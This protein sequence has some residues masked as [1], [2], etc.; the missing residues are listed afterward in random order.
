MEHFKDAF[1]KEFGK[2]NQENFGNIFNEIDLKMKN[3]FRK[4]QKIAAIIISLIFA[5]V[6][7][8]IFLPPLNIRSIETWIF[9][10]LTFTIFVS[11]SGKAFKSYKLFR[12]VLVGLILLMLILKIPGLKIFNSR[13]YANIIKIENSKFENDIA[14][15]PINKIPTIDRDS[16]IKLGSRKMGELLDL[17]SQFDIDDTTYTQINYKDQPIRVTPLKYNG[18]IKYIFNMSQGLP[19][20]LKVDIV[21]GNTELTKL[22]NKIKISKEDYFFRNVWRYARLR[23]PSEIFDNISFEIDENG[24]PYWVI[25]TYQPKI[26]IF[27]GLDVNGAILINVSTGEHTKYDLNNI[28]KW[29]DRI[30]EAD[31]IIEQLDWNGLYQGGYINSLFAQK[32]VLKTTEG[33]N[34]LALNDDVY[35]YTGYTSVAGDESNV[36]F[37]LS[38]MRTKETK[39]YPVSS[40]KEQS[41]MESAEGA[42]QEKKYK[43]TFPLLLN[44]KNKPTYF[45]SLKDNAGLIKLYAFIDAQDYQKVSVGNTVAQALS[46]HLGNS[47]SIQDN[48]KKDDK[49][50]EE[51][52][53]EGEITDIKQVV[54]KGNTHY[55]FTL[56]SSNEIFVSDISLSEKLPFLKEGQNIKFQ[57]EKDNINK[58]IIIEEIK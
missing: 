25:P 54:I 18:F 32:N 53:L 15:L 12:G 34:Y 8:Y 3:K 19:G 9:V 20:Y 42:V 40:A 13:S 7:F 2:N 57:Y 55:Y 29:L 49:K 47:N 50:K 27:D 26:F 45:L 30:Y 52:S 44:I 58:V 16:S 41:A 51:L 43:S 56:N 36:G 17:V 31:N 10:I 5:L 21:N 11:I 38:N 4:G 48:D 23:Y 39:F 24:V 14:Q 46:N 35:L 28:P 1:K 37:I 6:Y 22:D 33:Y